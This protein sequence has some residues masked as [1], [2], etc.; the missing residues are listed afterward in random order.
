M[1]HKT[2]MFYVVLLIAAA[3]VAFAGRIMWQ[4]LQLA[5]QPTLTED[6][7][8][9]RGRLRMATRRI[10]HSDRSADWDLTEVLPS[11]G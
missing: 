7:R 2:D 1:G 10:R 8:R 11:R 3:V 5:P 9:A 4:G 6:V